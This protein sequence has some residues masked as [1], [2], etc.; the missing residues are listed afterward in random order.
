[1]RATAVIALI[2][3]LALGVA[4]PALIA[5]GTLRL[6]SSTTI[7]LP[8]PAAS[9]YNAF[10]SVA[11]SLTYEVTDCPTGRTCVVSI[12]AV[13]PTVDA[14]A[15]KSV[16]DVEWQLDGTA[17][18]FSLST[19]PGRVQTIVTGTG[20]GRINFRM[21]LSWTLDTAGRDYLADVRLALTQQ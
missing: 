14:T 18:W 17:G 4:T 16:T 13:S 9:D 20:G 5:Q 21:R 15:T 7:T 1:M 10:H 12:Y 11:G 8:S 19:L 3:P 2:V 6:V